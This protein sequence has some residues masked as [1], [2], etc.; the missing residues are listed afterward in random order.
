MFSR[1]ARVVGNLFTVVDAAK[2]SNRVRLACE[3]LEDRCTPS[4]SGTGCC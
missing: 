3:S 2:P 1:I 4:G